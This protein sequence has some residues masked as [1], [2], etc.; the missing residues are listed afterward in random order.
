MT[1]TGKKASLSDYLRSKYAVEIQNTTYNH[2]SRFA[3]NSITASGTHDPT[4]I[5]TLTK[6]Y[7]E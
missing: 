4:Q 1:I 2:L 7:V 3:L 5:S 6:I